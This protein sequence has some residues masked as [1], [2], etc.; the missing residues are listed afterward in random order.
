MERILV[1]DDNKQNIYMAEILFTGNGF[2]VE[3]ASNGKE[4]LEKARA[5]PPDM[6]ISDI[7]MPVM[8]GFALCRE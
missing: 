8:D 3:T 6:V 7:L 1:V 5:N 4:A 2:E